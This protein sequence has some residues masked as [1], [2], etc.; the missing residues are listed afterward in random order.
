MAKQNSPKILAFIKKVI[1]PRG[2]ICKAADFVSNA[3]LGGKRL[4]PYNDSPLTPDP[5]PIYDWK[6]RICSQIQ[7][8]LIIL[9]EQP[10]FPIQGRGMEGPLQQHLGSPGYQGSQMVHLA[11]ENEGTL[12]RVQV[13]T[14]CFFKNAKK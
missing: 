4:I 1:I 6:K 2:T 10:V 3:F 11:A 8:L 5:S 9:Q 13:C 14:G 7:V 12:R